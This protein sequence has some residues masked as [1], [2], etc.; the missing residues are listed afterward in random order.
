M[1]QIIFKASTKF[2]RK[3]PQENLSEWCN[4]EL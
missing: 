4:F 2:K 3:K 1:M